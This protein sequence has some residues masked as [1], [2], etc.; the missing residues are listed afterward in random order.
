MEKPDL[1]TVVLMNAST[2]SVASLEIQSTICLLEHSVVTFT[3]HTVVDHV[4]F[5]S[6]KLL[7]CPGKS[8]VPSVDQSEP[9]PT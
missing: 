5:H 9:L 7:A 4:Y 6:F 3:H 2:A 8:L 1:S